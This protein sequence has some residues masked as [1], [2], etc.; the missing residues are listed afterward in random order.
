MVTPWEVRDDR[1]ARER[2]AEEPVGEA[3]ILELRRRYP[4]GVGAG[5]QLYEEY[6][7][8]GRRSST[9]P[10]TPTVTRDMAVLQEG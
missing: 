8:E 7:A 4:A 6:A 5:L 9:S 1:E 3:N 10:A 2:L